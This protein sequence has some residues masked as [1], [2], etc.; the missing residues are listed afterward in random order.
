MKCIIT[1]PERLPQA[2]INLAKAFSDL[3]NNS[4]DFRKRVKQDL[5]KRGAI[6]DSSH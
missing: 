6:K 1:N 3:Y 2:S 5:I 4:P